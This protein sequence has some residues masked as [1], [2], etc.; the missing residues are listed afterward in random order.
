MFLGL[1]PD[2]SVVSVFLTIFKFGEAL[3]L[4]CRIVESASGHRSGVCVMCALCCVC[5]GVRVLQCHPHF[6]VYLLDALG[7]G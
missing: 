3:Q 2:V 1:M 6:L 7:Y 5:L 4:W